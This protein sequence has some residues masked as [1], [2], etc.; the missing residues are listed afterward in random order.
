M[1]Y[2]KVMRLVMKNHSLLTN[3]TALV[4]QQLAGRGS[5]FTM[6]V[7][8]Q[9]G[10]HGPV[11]QS[12]LF[13]CVSYVG[14]DFSIAAM[15]PAKLNRHFTINHS[16]MKNTSADYFETLLKSQKKQSTA[17]LSKVSV[18]E[19]AFEANYL[20]AEIIAQK[21]KSHTVGENLILSA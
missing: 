2:D 21:R 9:W 16:H 12:V 4:D 1:K 11:I 17:S 7:I 10:S 6:N 19:K 15:V 14:D 18:R 13:Y 20:A 3:S 8:Y 5:A